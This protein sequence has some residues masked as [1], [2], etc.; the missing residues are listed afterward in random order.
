MKQKSGY[1][2]HSAPKKIW[3]VGQ[4]LDGAG[5]PPSHVRQPYQKFVVVGGWLRVILVLRLSFKLNNISIN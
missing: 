2:A 5:S 3:R 4:T 1:F